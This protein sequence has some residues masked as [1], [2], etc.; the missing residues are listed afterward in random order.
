MTITHTTKTADLRVGTSVE[1]EV[2][3]EIECSAI[4]ARHA[5]GRLALVEGAQL[6]IFLV[7]Y[8]LDGRWVVFSV[9]AGLD[10][11]RAS[12]DRL[13]L[14]VDEIDSDGERAVVV[15]GTGCEIIE[16]LDEASV[17]E[18]LAARRPHEASGAR[19]VRIVPRDVS[20]RQ[21][22]PVA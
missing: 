18:R 15:H 1:T 17:R 16:G 22:T 21:T 9:P 20:G 6:N 4:L 7:H 14:E 10:L 11:D 12:L 2:L 3:D 19:W 13:A 5:L 8:K